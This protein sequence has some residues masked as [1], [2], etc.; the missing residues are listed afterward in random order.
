MFTVFFYYHFNIHDVTSFIS[1]IS[2]LCLLFFLSLARGL[3]IVLLFSKN[4]HTLSW[5]KA[6]IMIWL[7][8]K[9]SVKPK[10]EFIQWHDKKWNFKGHSC[11]CKENRLVYS[12]KN[13]RNLPGK[14]FGS[15]RERM[16]THTK[17]M[18]LVWIKDNGLM[19]NK[20]EHCPLSRPHPSHSH[21]GSSGYSHWLVYDTPEAHDY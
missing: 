11:W 14:E 12:K 5:E 9:S 19:K 10:M 8:T 18:L 13:Q 2:N 21:H 16:V 17:I 4:Q 7:F 3:S 20:R 1:N 15:L 6:M